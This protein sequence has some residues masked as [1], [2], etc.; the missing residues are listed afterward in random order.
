M[1]LI[2]F[3]ETLYYIFFSLGL[4]EEDEQNFPLAIIYPYGTKKTKQAHLTKANTALEAKNI[5]IR[6]IPDTLIK[7][8]GVDLQDMLIDSF[9]SAPSRFPVLFITG[10]SCLFFI[11]HG[12]K[13]KHIISSLKLLN[14]DYPVDYSQIVSIPD[15]FVS[16]L[17]FSYS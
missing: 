12:G 15:L 9:S 7:M 13:T 17:V 11:P 5:I 6:S 8:T 1:Y 14:T 10:E 16:D 2:N 4:Q 3:I